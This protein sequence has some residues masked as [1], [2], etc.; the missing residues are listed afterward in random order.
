[1]ETAMKKLNFLI[2]A[3]TLAVSPFALANHDGTSGD[4]CQRH[5]GKQM[6]DADTNGD[7]SID[8]AEAQAQHD[9]HFDEMDTNHDGKL[10]KDEIAACKH[11]GHMGGGMHDKCHMGGMHD[12]GSQ[13]FKGADKDNDGTLDREEAKKLPHVSKNFD[14]IDVDHDGTVSRDE[15]HNYMRDHADA[16]HARG[17]K[18]FADADKDNDGTLTKEEAKKLPRVY[19]NFDAIDAD[20]DG[21]VSRDEVHDY[22]QQHKGN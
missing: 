5:G 22:M 18:A 17:S 10:S 20:H 14:A 6:M 4:H 12:K 19:K 9:K 21:T 16:V 11:E 1:M 3:G 15:V 8:K 13:A 2:L 7:G